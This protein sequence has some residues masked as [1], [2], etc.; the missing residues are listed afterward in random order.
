MFWDYL[1]NINLVLVNMEIS[2]FRSYENLPDI[3]RMIGI[4]R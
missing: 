1:F 2:D 3:N 4:A